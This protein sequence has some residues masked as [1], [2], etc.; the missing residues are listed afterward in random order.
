MKAAQQ[1]EMGQKKLIRSIAGVFLV[2]ALTQTSVL[3]HQPSIELKLIGRFATGIFDGRAAE[4]VA[5]DPTTQRLFVANEQESQ[6]DVLDIHDPTNPVA[7]R[8][9]DVSPYGPDPNSVA[10]H[11]GVVA[12]AVEGPARTDPGVVVFFDP[13]GQFLS[14]VT[15]GALPD[16]LTFTPNGK[17][18]LVANEGEPND[19]YTVDPEGSISIIDVSD[20]AQNVTQADVR[21]ADF[22]GFNSATL[23]PSIRIFGPGATVAQDLEPEY[24]TVSHNSQKAWVSLEEN[25]ALAVVD[26]KSA[27]VEKLVGLGF[28]NHNLPG[29]GLDASD[30]DN[31]INIR[32]W[33]VSGMYQPDAIASYRFR[34]ET[35]LVTAN[36]GDNRDYPGFGER[37]RV[38]DV[39]LDPAVFQN[40]AD[41]QQDANLGRFR[42][43]QVNGDTDNDG[44]FD[45]LFSFGARSFSIW[46]AAG[47]LVF[48]SGD[49]F[50]QIT[51]AR[52]PADFNS[53]SDNNGS[54]D[55]RSDDRGPEPQ[56][57][58][59][60][61]AFGSTYAFIGLEF[62]GGIMV[63]NISN[64]LTP[65]FVQYIN[66]R[67]FSGDPQAGTA[68]DLAPEGVIF[69]KA[70]DSP[71]GKPLL[72]VANVVS[73]T[74]TIFEIR[75]R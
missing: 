14:S 41:L 36:E 15:V 10:V 72:V 30:R 42:I 51:A 45:Q 65:S 40:A 28:K 47:Q 74:T 37:V 11:R 58:V 52:L 67:D 56:G 32:P 21:T 66:T 2:A 29:N 57:V 23:D 59:I 71:N 46:T 69:I 24:L 62:I 73:G 75:S 22:T 9:I 27:K 68:G 48:D 4:I 43:T 60:G 18:V 31:A 1:V 35:Y 53:D 64:P 54:F 49:D 17:K 5:H 20:G 39:K 61:K 13:N 38:K 63:Y 44:D 26:I 25:N 19:E 50:E 8:P 3:A 6:V 55:T 70:K 16:M 34:G 7:L 33:P 12:V